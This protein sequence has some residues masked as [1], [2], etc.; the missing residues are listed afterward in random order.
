MSH[1]RGVVCANFGYLRGGWEPCRQAWHATCYTVDLPKDPFPRGLVKKEQEIS[2][3]GT[4][5]DEFDGW[6]LSSKEKVA[7]QTMYLCARPGDHLMTPFQCQLCHFRNCFQREP[8]VNNDQDFWTIQCMTRANLD[9][10]WSKRPSTVRGNLGEFRRFIRLAKRFGVDSP[11]I[12]YPRGPFPLT[13][14]FGMIPAI[15][16]LQRSFDPGQNSATIQ[17]DTMRNLRSCFSNMVHTTPFGVGGSTMT[18]GK[19]S[20]YVT[21]SPTNTAWFNRFM[22]GTHER[23]G[24]VKIQD[25]P[26]T[27]DMLLALQDLLEHFW[28]EAWTAKNYE[29]LF[30]LATIGAT[31]TNGFSAGLRGEELGNVRYQDSLLLSGLGLDHPR[32]PHIVLALEGRFKGQISRKRHKVPLVTVSKSGIQN[33]RWL[34]RLLAELHRGGTQYGPLFR[35]GI[36]TSDP[37]QIKHLDIYFHKYLLLL[38]GQRPDLLPES[39]DI[40]NDFSIRRS[41]RRGSTSQARNKK[42]PRDVINLNNR[43][44]TEDKAGHRHTSNGEMMENYTDAVAALETILQYSEPL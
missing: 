5:I 15:A 14:S 39:V 28:S 38:Q 20:S 26:L 33:Q 31:I 18:N 29:L 13:D 35:K 22:T 9:A 2:G 36:N 25:A 3:D 43:W 32:K 19:K 4:V 34:L 10:F 16:S 44:R 12:S 7:L 21:N 17:W 27:I 41:L 42:I 24:D 23:M 37:A 6:E 8:R 11:C 1:T 40:I 30:E